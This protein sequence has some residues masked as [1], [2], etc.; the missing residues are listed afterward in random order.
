VINV[1][2]A[3]YADALAPSDLAQLENLAEF[4]LDVQVTTDAAAGYAQGSCQTDD[5]CAA[6]C[7]SACSSA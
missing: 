6:T 2:L 5:T 7:E 4:E 1:P 3:L